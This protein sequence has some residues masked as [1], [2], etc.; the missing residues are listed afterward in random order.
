[1]ISVSTL[2]KTP[3]TKFEVIPPQDVGGDTFYG[4]TTLSRQ[5]SAIGLAESLLGRAMDLTL[6]FLQRVED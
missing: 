1:M 5:F 4:N 3:R 2:L 6:N